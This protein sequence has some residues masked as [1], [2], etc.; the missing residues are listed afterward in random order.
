LASSLLKNDGQVLLNTGGSDFD[1]LNSFLAINVD[2][3]ELHYEVRLVGGKGDLNLFNFVRLN[4][5]LRGG[6][7]KAVL[8][9]LLHKVDV[10]SDFSLVLE[11]D[12]L[13]LLSFNGDE[14]EVN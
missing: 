4:A 2:L 10:A 9:A 14:L 1:V 3:D 7:F 5:E 12:F 8:L 11:F 6:Y 13:V